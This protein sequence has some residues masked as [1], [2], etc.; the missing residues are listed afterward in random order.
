MR[1][2]HLSGTPSKME[3]DL[4]MLRYRGYIHFKPHYIEPGSSLGFE[5]VVLVSKESQKFKMNA[6]TFASLS[7]FCCQILKGTE[8]AANGNFYIQTEFSALELYKICTFAISGQIFGYQTEAELQ[9]DV[10]VKQLFQTIGVN[11]ISLNFN[12]RSG[13][14]QWWK[15]YEVKEEIDS[16]C[17][18]NKAGSREAASELLGI[19]E[20]KK[21]IEIKEEKNEGLYGSET[22]EIEVRPPVADYEYS[23]SEDFKGNNFYD[24]NEWPYQGEDEPLKAP[25]KRKKLAKKK[26]SSKKAKFKEP[27][28]GMVGKDNLFWFPQEDSLRNSQCKYQCNLCVRSFNVKSDFNQHVR[29]HTAKCEDDRYFCFYC[30]GYVAFKREM[31]LRQHIQE[32][33][34]DNQTILKCP[35]CDKTYRYRDSASRL[36][37]HIQLNHTNESKQCASCGGEY[38]SREAMKEHQKKAGI[39]HDTKC[40]VCPDFQ[41]K[42]WEENLK[43]L[44]SHHHG[45][46]QHKCG[47][48]PAYFAYTNH[49]QKHHEVC[50]EK[51]KQMSE[52]DKNNW[53]KRKEKSVCPHCAKKLTKGYMQKHINSEHGTHQIKCTH[54]GCTFIIRHP[55]AVK[56]HM[57]TVHSSHTCEI[58]GWVGKQKKH[59]VRHKISVHTDSD[60]KPFKCEVC[61]KG[62]HCSNSLRDHINTHTG[63]KPYKCPECGQGFGSQGTMR[64]H[65]RAVHLGLKRNK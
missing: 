50:E 36:Q 30:E 24:E 3:A 32:N 22:M 27:E 46:M 7:H 6:L 45:E 29:R 60:K 1:H 16:K 25:Q 39:F 2:F 18:E 51:Y 62:F 41:A 56:D 53:D 48:C 23:E 37:E 26:S 38:T 5:N 65:L 52:T 55:T 49:R 33:H 13:L 10:N 28:S 59:L 47:F 9:Q 20:I 4:M 61:N 17:N 54:P 15:Q 44:N 12:S 14:E 43:H 40:R 57:I 34:K 63:A 8:E 64:G 42:T 58:C 21:L 35:Y 11:I 31:A 19:D